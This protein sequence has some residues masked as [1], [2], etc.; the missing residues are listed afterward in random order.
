MII[1]GTKSTFMSKL[2]YIYNCYFFF[3]RTLLL[4]R[5]CPRKNRAKYYDNGNSIK[6]VKLCQKGP[7]IKTF[8]ATKITLLWPRNDYQEQS[9]GHAEVM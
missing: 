5:Q 1:L 8:G 4:S 6:V 3:R 2:K 7:K 9:V